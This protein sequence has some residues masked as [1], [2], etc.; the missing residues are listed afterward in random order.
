MTEPQTTGIPEPEGPTDIIDTN[1]EVGQDN[2]QRN[3]GTLAF[4]VHNPVF[5][6]S[7]LVIVA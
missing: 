3:I 6:I 4:D 2:V 5:A 7:G 1:Y